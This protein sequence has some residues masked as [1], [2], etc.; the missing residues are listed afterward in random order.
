MLLYNNGL[1]VVELMQ[2]ENLMLVDL[3]DIQSNN[4]PQVWHALQFV[5]EHINARE[6]TLLLLDSSKSVVEVGIEEYAA[7]SKQFAMELMTTKLQK[8]ARVAS[9]DN[10][11]E[12]KVAQA[13]SQI[14]KQ[15]PRNIT[16]SNFTRREEAVAWLLG[17]ENHDK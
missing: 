15:V 9:K 2:E 5:L 1:L 17:R 6:V 13:S 11:R 16:F 10:Q 4:L 8:V 12:E 3:P 14:Q 7:V